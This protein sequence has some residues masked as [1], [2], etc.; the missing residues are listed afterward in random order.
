MADT[1]FGLRLVPKA[2]VR[3]TNEKTRGKKKGQNRCEENSW[4]NR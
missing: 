4:M 2:K 1:V 3:K